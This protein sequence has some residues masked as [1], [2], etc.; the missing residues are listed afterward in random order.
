MTNQ[1]VKEGNSADGKDGARASDAA[2]L[3]DAEVKLERAQEERHN[4]D[5]PKDEAP[6]AKESTGHHQ[7]DVHFEVDGEGFDIPRDEDK[8][9]P[10]Y[11]IRTYAGRDPESNYLVKITGKHPVSYEGKGDS[12]IKIHDGDKFQ[13]VSTGP[14]PVSDVQFRTGAAAFVEGLKQLG[15][16]PVQPDGRADM[17]YF[18]YEVMVGNRTGQKLK[19]GLIIPPDYPLTPPSGPHISARLYPNASGGA[20][21]TG[22]IHDSPQFEQSVGG[23]WQYWSRPFQEWAKSKKTVAVYMAHVYR[24]WE[25]Q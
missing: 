4:A 9:T 24:L 12:P 14:T 25:T 13:T 17:V 10:N 1:D 3:Q 18:D 7:H 16:D 6:E 15:Y 11:I 21:P 2:R 20:H 5:R 8:Q 22:G 19:L 23:Q